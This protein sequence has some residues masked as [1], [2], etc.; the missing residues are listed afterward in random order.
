MILLSNRREF[1]YYRIVI[2]LN[3]S[4]SNN[5]SHDVPIYSGMSIRVNV[6]LTFLLFVTSGKRTRLYY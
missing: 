3:Y 5:K 2:T 4:H 1:V 6:Y